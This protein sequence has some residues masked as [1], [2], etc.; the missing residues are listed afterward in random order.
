MVINTEADP[1]R[2]AVVSTRQ[3]PLLEARTLNRFSLHARALAKHRQDAL[4]FRAT[5]SIDVPPPA[6][7]LRETKL[8]TSTILTTLRTRTKSPDLIETAPADDKS[9]RLLTDGARSFVIDYGECTDLPTFPDYLEPISWYYWSTLVLQGHIKN[10]P[11]R[12]FMFNSLINKRKQSKCKY[13]S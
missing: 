7:A 6:T 12:M 4:G 2:P 5:N 9:T 11:D 13:F 8:A 10:A 3:A 1:Q